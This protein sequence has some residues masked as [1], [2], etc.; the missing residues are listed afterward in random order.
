MREIETLLKKN[1]LGVVAVVRSWTGNDRRAALRQPLT[2]LTGKACAL[3]AI[4]RL[5]GT[6]TVYTGAAGNHLKLIAYAKNSRSVTK[7]L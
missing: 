2:S 1:Y 5:S 6:L 3:A 4:L 7:D